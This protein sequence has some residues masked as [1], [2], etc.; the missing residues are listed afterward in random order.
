MVAKTTT[1]QNTPAPNNGSG[2]KL[3]EDEVKH[4]PLTD[5]FVDSEWNARSIANTMAESNLRGDEEGRGII[6]LQDGLCT[7]GQDEPVVLRRTDSAD[8]YKKNVNKPYALVVGFRRF[9]AIRRLNA[10]HDLLKRRAEE[11]RTVVPNTANGTIRAV[12]RSLT[13]E[14]ARSLNMR[15][16][17]QRDSLSPPDL[18]WGMAKLA[19]LGMTQTVIGSTL[20]K[21]QS[22]VSTLLRISSLKPS[23][24]EHWRQ[25]GEFKGHKSKSQV[26]TKELNDVAKLDA[27]RQEEEYLKILQSK[28]IAPGTPAEESKQ[29]LDSAKKKA[30]AI[31]FMLGTCHRVKFLKVAQEK[32]WIDNIEYMMKVGKKKLTRQELRSIANAAEKGFKA[33]VVEPAIE[34]EEE[35][36]EDE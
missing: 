30:H 20:G 6:G 29:W 17:T 18:M 4:I 9:E 32:N 7:D 21:T 19:K 26:T 31:G 11:N 24:I 8:F 12:V 33:G 34:E 25:G 36:E 35:G 22:Y 2:I 23:I 16:N 15:E 5:V 13:E 1:Q 14:Q 28:G 10:D 3:S 27:D